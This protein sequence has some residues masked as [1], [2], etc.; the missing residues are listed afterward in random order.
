MSDLQEMPDEEFEALHRAVL[1]ESDRRARIAQTVEQVE[2]ITAT[3]REAKGLT[4][5]TAWVPP[6]GAHDA[7]PA[8]DTRVFEGDLWR[9]VSGVPLAHSPA[10]YPA[11][12]EQVGEGVEPTPP[13][14]AAWPPWVDGQTYEIDDVRSYEGRVY[15]CT[16]AHTAHLGAMWIPPAV[17][18]LWSLVGGALPVD[19][20]EPEPDPEPEPEPEPEFPAWNP[21]AR[22][23]VG[24]MVV[25]Q[26]LV[27]KCLVAH[28]AEQQGMWRPGVA[29]TVWSNQ[30]PAV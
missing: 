29:H 18:A 27:W 9:N 11:G 26:D 17:P 3:Y 7:V 10:D 12:W 8:G 23:E 16:Q 13:D 28:G 24:D 1:L 14:P 15:R 19:P 20:P 5:G 4:D 25:H 21:D 6:T 22:Y 30:G 2:T